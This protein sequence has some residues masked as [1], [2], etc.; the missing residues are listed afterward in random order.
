MVY[1]LSTRQVRRHHGRL[2]SIQGVAFS[3]DGRTLASAADD[4]KIEV[5]DV[6]PEGEPAPRKQASVRY[7]VFSRDGR[8]MVS[9]STKAA[10]V[11][12]LE[13]ADQGGFAAIF[14]GMILGSNPCWTPTP[15]TSSNSS[16]ESTA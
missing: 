16:S 5:W 1:D 10:K 11:R 3:P 14:R 2:S 13:I 9:A 7:V 15:K 12:Q 4:G 8:V 6:E